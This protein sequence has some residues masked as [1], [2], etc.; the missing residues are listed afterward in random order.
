MN[1]PMMHVVNPQTGESD[2]AQIRRVF[3]SQL[4]TA[5]AWRES[6]AAERIARLKKLRDGM[7]ARREDF[8]AAF[9]TASARSGV[10]VTPYT[11]RHTGAVWAAEGGASM[12][13]LA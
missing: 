7:M 10:H 5:L 3:E 11:L 8:Y 13:E 9:Q 4:A 2:P 6:T 12:D 1:R